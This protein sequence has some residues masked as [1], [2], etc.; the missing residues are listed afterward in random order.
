VCVETPETHLRNLSNDA[1][2]HVQS[3]RSMRIA[4][5]SNGRP[6]GA[7]VLADWWLG[8]L[9]HTAARMSQLKRLRPRN[10]IL[11]LIHPIPGI[12]WPGKH[13][14]ERQGSRPRQASAAPSLTS[15]FIGE[16]L[17]VGRPPGGSS[18]PAAVGIT[19]GPASA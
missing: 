1:L 12:L 11:W 9:A 19:P 2:M 5:D 13:E 17:H 15:A 8:D 10:S 18:L 3:I 7:R 16:A 6:I 14:S 4:H